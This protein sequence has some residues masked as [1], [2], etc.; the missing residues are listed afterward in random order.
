[1][2]DKK[3]A[4]QMAIWRIENQIKT[5]REIEQDVEHAPAVIRFLSSELLFLKGLLT[6]EREQIEQAYNS[7]MGDERYSVANK[8]TY[9]LTTFKTDGDGE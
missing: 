2:S 8:Q 1:M 4:M 6:T 3:T 9:F 7:G 5:L